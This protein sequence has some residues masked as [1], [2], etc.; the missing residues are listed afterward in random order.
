VQ[1]DNNS[2]FDS[3]EIDVQPASSGY[4]ASGL[5][6]ETAYYWRA[7]AYNSCGWGNWSVT[8]SFSLE[9]DGCPPPPPPTLATPA[10]GASDLSVPVILDWY[11]VSGALLY[12]LQVDDNANFSSPEISA[13]RSSSSY[14]ASGL[15]GG[16]TYFWHVRTYDACGW[17]DWSL[18]RSFT[19]EGDCSLPPPPSYQSPPNGMSNMSQPIP[20]NWSDVGGVS[21]YQVQVDDNSGFMNPEIDTEPTEP[22]YSANGLRR[23]TYYYWRVRSYNACGWGGWTVT[24]YFVTDPYGSDDQ[25][26]PVISNVYADDTTSST[27]T[28]HWTTNELAT[29]RVFYVEGL[30]S[31]DTTDIDMSYVYTHEVLLEGLYPDTYY[32]YRVISHDAADNEAISE[33]YVFKTGGMGLD[34]DGEGPV[35]IDEPVY[36]TSQP[37][38]VVRN[39]NANYDITYYFEVTTDSSFFYTEAESRPPVQQKSGGTTG[40]KVPIRLAQDQE[41]YWRVRANEGEYSKVSIFTI[42]AKPHPYPNPFDA[43][44]TPHVTFTEIPPGSNLIITTINGEIVRTWSYVSGNDIIWD[45]SNDHGSAVSPG[46][47]LWYIESTD[48]CGKLTVI[49]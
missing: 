32:E 44:M 48:F 14:S 21:K 43:N 45:G 49:R 40:W 36:H 2:N 19:T 31:G 10:D 15:D 1:V 37:T 11:D 24:R 25:T 20:L 9:E 30:S 29:S 3:P 4:S 5:A 34:V 35:V 23:L 6:S 22:Q 17:G 47:Y 13:Q 42:V 41:Y 27:A 8:R 16:T 33:Y 7:R 28:V 38:L 26:P 12:Q 46:V 39:L 18:V